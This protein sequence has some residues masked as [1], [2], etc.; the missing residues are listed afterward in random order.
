MPVPHRY[1]DRYFL[2]D[3][4]RE[5]FHSRKKKYNYFTVAKLVSISQWVSKSEII[6]DASLGAL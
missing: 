3:G 6:W 4:R 2:L 1:S 5:S